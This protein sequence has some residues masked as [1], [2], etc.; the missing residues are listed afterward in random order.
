M[1]MMS[2]DLLRQQSKWKDSLQELRD[3]FAQLQGEQG[4]HCFVGTVT[5]VHLQLK[6]TLQSP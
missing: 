6:G 2:I 4:H 5:I 1:Q 3:I